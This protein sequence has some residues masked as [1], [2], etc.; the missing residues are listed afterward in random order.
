[1]RDLFFKIIKHILQ[2][3][4]LALSILLVW[5]LIHYLFQPA[6]WLL[7]TPMMVW[8]RFNELWFQGNLSFHLKVTLLEITLGYGLGI[9][10]GFLV[11][12]PISQVRFF[13]K[14]LTPYLIAGNSIPLV[15]FAPLLILWVGNGIMTKIIVTA[16][17][18]FLP[19]TISTL[20]GF[21]TQKPL[22]K[23][24]M[25]TL[26]S[27]KWQRF[28]YVEL[29]SAMPGILSGMKIGAPLAVVGAV[30]GEFLGSGEGLGHLILEANGLIDT[31]QLFVANIIL[32]IVGILFFSLIQIFETLVLGKW[33]HRRQ[34]R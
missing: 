11:G 6:T 26:R 14:I 8:T 2:F 23:R 25:R 1:M 18:V 28:L 17:I 20:T 4:Y 34:S 5:L 3:L 10:A 32:G 21:R 7:P 27:R 30:V 24:L 22:L 9:S 33:D 29:P 19:M 31:A 13:E 16:I 15:A 12:Y